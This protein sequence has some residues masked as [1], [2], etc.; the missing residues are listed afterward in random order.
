[1]K[2]QITHSCGHTREIEVKGVREARQYQKWLG[3]QRCPTCKN[4]DLPLNGNKPF[5][6]LK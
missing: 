1:M 4:Y 3:S 6:L 5:S 2:A